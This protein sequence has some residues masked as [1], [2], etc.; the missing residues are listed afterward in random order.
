MNQ[1]EWFGLGT[2]LLGVWQL[3]VAGRYVVYLFDALFKISPPND[4]SPFPGGGMA[5]EYVFYAVGYTVLGVTLLRGADFL[6]AFS[7]PAPREENGEETTDDS[8]NNE[9]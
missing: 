5:T 2:R 9:S 3:V 6:T 4:S 7:Y 1:K 8:P